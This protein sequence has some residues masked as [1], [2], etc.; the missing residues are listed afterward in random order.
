MAVPNVALAAP[1]ITTSAAPQQLVVPGN[2]VGE[3]G[4]IADSQLKAAGFKNIQYA[5]GTSGVH[6]VILYQNWTVQSV[7][8]GPGTPVSADS[9]LVVTMTKNNR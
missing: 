7:E 1:A 3:N 9:P 4:A 8:P 6:M 5:S 2:L